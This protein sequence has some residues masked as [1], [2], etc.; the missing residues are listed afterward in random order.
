MISQ[1]LIAECMAGS[2][3]AIQALVRTYQHSVYRLSFSLLDCAG[4]DQAATAAQAEIAVR[5]TFVI[6]LNRLGRYHADIQFETWLYAIAIQASQRRAAWQYRARWMRRAPGI[7]GG[8]RPFWRK[9]TAGRAVPPAPGVEA[10]PAAQERAR[11]DEVLWQAVCA[12]QDPLRLLVILRYAHNFPVEEIAQMLNT[13]KGAVHARLNRAREAI[14]AQVELADR[15]T[16][17]SGAASD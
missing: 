12:L 1:D 17:H 13:S 16:F 11:R 10:P 3:P 7:G 15:N 2:E 14:A 8:A 9:S 4:V 5:D 6:A